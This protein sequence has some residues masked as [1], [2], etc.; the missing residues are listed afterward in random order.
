MR[1]HVFDSKVFLFDIVLNVGGVLQHGLHRPN[2]CHTR[3]VFETSVVTLVVFD[4]VGELLLTLYYHA[5]I[6]ASPTQR[7]YE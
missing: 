3:C 4:C 6:A 5:S 2:R 1:M 7:T